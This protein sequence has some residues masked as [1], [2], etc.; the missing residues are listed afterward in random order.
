MRISSISP[1]ATLIQVASSGCAS[2]TAA[3]TPC[4]A[5]FLPHGQAFTNRLP[6]VVD[7]GGNLIIR[8]SASGNSFEYSIAANNGTGPIVTTANV[9]S[10]TNPNANFDQ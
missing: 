3:L 9:A 8:N 10:N 7:G 2:E 6:P 1:T 4:C 5:G